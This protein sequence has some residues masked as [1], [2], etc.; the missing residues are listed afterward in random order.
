AVCGRSLPLAAARV[1]DWVIDELDRS[2]LRGRGGAGLPLARKWESV[3]AGGAALGDRYAV[4]N[5]AEGEPGTF[6]DRPLLRANPYQLLEGR[7]VA[8]T[9]LGAREAFV[10]VKTSFTQE[11]DALERALPEMAAADLLC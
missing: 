11:I 4:A 3:R 10:A 7:C 8:A 5:G 6:K 1:A 2:G 9:L